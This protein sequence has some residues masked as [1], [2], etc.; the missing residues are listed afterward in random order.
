MIPK[1]CYVIYDTETFQAER[2]ASYYSHS[3]QKYVNSNPKL[4]WINTTHPAAAETLAKIRKKTERGGRVNEDQ[5][6]A[7]MGKLEEIRCGVVDVESATESNKQPSSGVKSIMLR[8]KFFAKLE[9]RTG[10]GRNQVK[11]AFNDALAECV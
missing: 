3:L 8:E 2:L 11:D 9:A 5:F 4:G 10:W 1:G 7:L 6:L